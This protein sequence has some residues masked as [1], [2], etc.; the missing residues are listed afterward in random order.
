VPTH[1]KVFV[2]QPQLADGL[3]LVVLLPARD[4]LLRA[5][6]RAV[7]EDQVLHPPAAPGSQGGLGGYAQSPKVL[8]SSPQPPKTLLS[9][10][11]SL[12]TRV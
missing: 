1:L 7:A 2:E 3:Q 6:L 9:P 11:C 10:T 5:G 4:H 8:G 12:M